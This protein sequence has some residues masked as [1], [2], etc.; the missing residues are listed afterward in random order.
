[1]GA[2]AVAVAA[3][4]LAVRH[5]PS[6]VRA[7]IPSGESAERAA[8]RMVS[9]ASAVAA[10]LE[11][12]GEWGEA[13]SEQEANAWLAHDLPRL[14]AGRLPAG[15]H[16]LSVRFHPR[17]LACSGMIGEGVAAARWWAILEVS[18]PHADELVIAVDSA[19]LG[20]VPVPGG[21][22]LST[23]ERLAKT[24]RCRGELRLHDGR[25]R[26]HLHLPGSRDGAGAVGGGYHLEGLRIDEGELVFAGS[27]RP[28]LPRPAPTRAP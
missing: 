2:I 9:K 25:T 6:A 5:H 14:A 21:V 15:W 28:V 24:A 13:V 10:G 27:T 12:A 19:G 23:L 18:L 7:S 11:R 3:M 17:R 4:A 22:V 1:M 8:A 26:L 20:L 16:S